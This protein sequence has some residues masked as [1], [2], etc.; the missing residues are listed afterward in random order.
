MKQLTGQVAVVTGAAGGIGLAM[1]RLF[2]RQGMKLA[3]I[4]TEAIATIMGM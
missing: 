4:V 2:A 1:A 3:H